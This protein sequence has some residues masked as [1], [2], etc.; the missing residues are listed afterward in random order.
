MVNIGFSLR[1]IQLFV[2]AA[3]TQNLTRVSERLHLTVPA[4][5]KQIKG[6]ESFYG[7]V[8][9]EK[10]GN[11]LV[12]TQQGRRMLPAANDVLAQAKIMDY[13]MRCLQQQPLHPLHLHMGNTYQS[14]V[15][16]ALEQF[17]LQ[18]ENTDYVLDISH[19]SEFQTVMATTP[20][21]DYNRDTLYIGGGFIDREN[22]Y[23]FYTLKKMKFVLLVHPNHPL[24][25]SNDVTAHDLRAVQWI[26][27]TSGSQVANAICDFVARINVSDPAIRLASFE[28]VKHALLVNLGVAMLPQYLVKGEIAQNRLVVIQSSAIPDIQLSMG[29]YHHRAMVLTQQQITFIQFMQEYYSAH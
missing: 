1:Q 7:V 6:L 5:S 12:L 14:A 16:A 2:L 8:L 29:L 27:S 20:V 3:K 11:R 24:V 23:Q 18:Y 9:F 4:V 21:E 13:K 15:F 26:V 10:K 17:N 25:N 19:W 28:S 22:C